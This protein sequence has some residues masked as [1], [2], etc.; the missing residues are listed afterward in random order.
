MKVD[1]SRKARKEVTDALASHLDQLRSLREEQRLA[2]R[3]M[4]G[5]QDATGKAILLSRDIVK[6]ERGIEWLRAILERFDQ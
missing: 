3:A 6:S 5:G 4:A 1:R 2:I